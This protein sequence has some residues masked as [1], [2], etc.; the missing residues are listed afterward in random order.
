MPDG[1]HRTAVEGLTVE[2]RSDPLGVD[3]A[4]P[5]FGWR[6]ASRVRGRRQ[7]AYRILVASSP[8]RLA[9]GR[10]DVW[11][12]GRTD[13]ADSV[14][15]RYAGPELHPSTCY[16]WT[17]Q[18]WDENG[19][20]LPDAPAARFETGLLST[21]GVRG[22]DG[23]QWI[24]MA[25]KG[26]NSPGSPLLRRQ[27]ALKT[28]RVRDAR[29]YVSALGV[30]DAYVNGQRVGVPQDGGTTY[31]LLTPGWTN[32]DTTVSYFT[33]DVTGLLADQQQVTLAAVLGNGWYNGRVSENSVYYAESGNR[34]ALK[35]KLLIRYED[36]S[37]Q[38]V[39]TTPGD[40]WRATDTG[41]YRADD[42]YDGQTYDARRELPGWTANGFDASAWSGVEEHDFTT[43]FPDARL[44]AYPGESARLMPAWD[45]RPRSIT[46]Y[47]G[48][49]DFVPDPARTV[50]DPIEAATAPLTLHP[51]DTAVIDLGQNLVGV[52][53]YTLR[54]PAGAEVV[55]Q[56]GEML[57]DTSAGADG[58]EGSVYRANLRTAGAA[59]TYILK[60][61]PKGETHQDSLTF[62]G[63]RHVRVTTTATVTLSELTGRVATSALHD[64]GTVETD[65][66]DV[67]QLISNVRWGQRGNYLWV[68]T[69]CPQR[70]ERC[71]W[72]GDTQLF[73]Q[74]GLYNTDA[75]A[76]LS[77]FQDILIDSQRTYGAD[78][79]QFTW[80]A[81]GAR[82]NEPDP[83]SGWADCGVVVPW[84]VWQMSGDTTVVD[85]SWDA[86]TTYMEWIRARTG[87]TYA[88]QGAIFGD[89]LAFQVT[90]TQ[91]VSDA[92]YAYS[93]RL[94]ADMARATARTAEAHAYEE[95]F[96][97]IKRAFVTKYLSTENGR[98]TVRSSLGSP[99]PWTPGGSP[100][101][102][103]DDSQTALLWVLKLGLY[104]TE[105]QRR[106]IVDLLV[107]NIGNSAEY[108]A[109]HPD[110]TRVGY[111][112]NTLSVGFLGVNV[113]AP[114]LTE[115]GQVELAYKVLHQDAMPSWLYSVRNGATT[116]WERWNSYSKED[117]FGPVEMNSFNHYAYG[118]IM[119]WMYESMA[120]IAKDPAHPGFRHFFLR[121]HLDPTGRIT[122][123]TGSHRSPYGEIV[124]AWTVRESEF[125]QRVAVPANSTATLRIPTADPDSVR[126]GGTPLSRV[127]QVT[128][129]SFEDGVAS[130]ELPSGRY[131]LTSSL[132]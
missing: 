62:Y 33:Y 127:P 106:A 56:P 121:P 114:V 102:T 36:G 97:H 108:K 3:A 101:R 96:A 67:N 115:E 113:L 89:W 8:A 37:A 126:E 40:D 69:D 118:A 61:D 21:D 124:S 43:R 4:R 29:L 18:V 86:M 84:T 74:T 79:A 47:T 60:G 39:V 38:T 57:N 63:F 17:V 6:T 11:D 65:D 66:A 41:P 72:T 131:E 132:A 122:R 93:A 85:R 35:A 23:A 76:F 25:G 78:G 82:Y 92:Y 117:G 64:I 129:L 24:S 42:I 71:G 77:H 15:V 103:E 73:S 83:A 120:G 91:L 30:Y 5:R 125:T 80:I 22:W 7:T 52:P 99:P 95:L 13:S 1:V 68:P 107:Q 45:R 100:T 116:I 31:E 109:A 19:S 81:P 59:S 53:R 10:A 87:D 16:H 44:V 110:S 128:Y 75:V 58:P 50:T 94:M 70:D 46:V 32:Y 27:T 123:V 111:A 14:A 90:S 12:S 112:E 88:G 20:R 104:D 26:P 49:G 55:L 119:E 2:H 34:L 54:G 98:L 9:E 48:G 51:G 28:G 105:A 130:Y